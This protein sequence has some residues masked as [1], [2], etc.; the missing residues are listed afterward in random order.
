MMMVMLFMMLII[1]LVVIVVIIVS[2]FVRLV[3]RLEIVPLCAAQTVLALVVVIVD[4]V[5][6]SRAVRQVRFWG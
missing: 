3:I 4:A 1:I 2:F 6:M 5:Q